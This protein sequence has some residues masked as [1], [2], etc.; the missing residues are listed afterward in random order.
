L[1]LTRCNVSISINLFPI[2]NIN[3]RTRGLREQRDT[4]RRVI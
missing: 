1:Y 3:F 2:L 4:I